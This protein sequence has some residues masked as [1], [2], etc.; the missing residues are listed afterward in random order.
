MAAGACFAANP[1][2]GMWKL[3]DAKPKPRA[4][5]GKS[6]TVTLHGAE[7]QNQVTVDGVDKDGNRLTEFGL[8]NSMEGLPAEREY[9]LNS[10][11]YKR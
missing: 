10:A 1:H 5:M 9:V 11:A 3:N 7:G 8:A 2:L 4:G 6:T